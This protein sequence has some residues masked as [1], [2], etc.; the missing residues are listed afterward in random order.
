MPEQVFITDKLPK[1]A[2]GKIQRRMMVK[3]F[4]K[5]SAGQGQGSSGQAA[6][7]PSQPRSRL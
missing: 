6:G 2:T 7:K 4:I 1:T 5:G 3:A